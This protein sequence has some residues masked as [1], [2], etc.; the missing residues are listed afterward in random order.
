MNARLLFLAILFTTLLFF[1]PFAQVITFPFLIFSTFIHESS[2]AIAAILTGGRVDS[3]T[4]SVNGSGVTYTR[5]GLQFIITSA[6]YLGTTFFGGVLLILSRK[7]NLTR[8]VLYATAML[9]SLVTALFVGHSNNLIVL[10]LLAMIVFLMA[11]PVKN[12]MQGKSRF[13]F[14]GASVGLLIL[15][16]SYLL[17]TGSL[18]S[19]T[20]GLVI[21]TALIAVARFAPLNFAHFFLTFLAVQ[22]CL[23][24]LDAIKTVYFLSLRSTC[25][26]DAASM[27]EITG[28]PAWFWAMLWAVVSFMI[29][30]ISA[31][32][33]V[34]KSYRESAVLAAH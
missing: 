7:Q 17:A 6:G 19:W 30:T 21:T 8:P 5:G 24:A 9:V 28:I 16:I 14:T 32:I 20:A 26:N 34:R 12:Q 10:A 22:C 29:L 31:T 13:Y 23:N 33:Y 3:L 11:I 4:V 1:L 27:A 2:H 25:A 15:L 18:F